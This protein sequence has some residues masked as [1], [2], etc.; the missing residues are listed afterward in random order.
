[1][2]AEPTYH[3]EVAVGHACATAAAQTP[4]AE[5][6]DG[7]RKRHAAAVGLFMCQE[8]AWLALVTRHK[9]L[10]DS[11]FTAYDSQSSVKG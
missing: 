2:S 1:M 11:G 6:L 3:V 4:C 8:T 10:R 7:S 5:P 9:S